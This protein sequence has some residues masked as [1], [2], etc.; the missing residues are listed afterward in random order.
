MRG[1]AGAGSTQARTPTCTS[2]P[3]LALHPGLDLYGF[4]VLSNSDRAP[5][6]I[7]VL[8]TCL[9]CWKLDLLGPEVLVW[10]W[11]WLEACSFLRTVP[12]LDASNLEQLD[13]GLQAGL[14][15]TRRVPVWV[16]GWLEA[17]GF[18]QT[19]P[20]LDASNL[21]QLDLGLQAGLVQTRR[22]PVW[23]WGWFEAFGFLQT[24]P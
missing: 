20:W 9:A 4:R 23:V 6:L 22:V 7:L 15:Q 19:V 18:L 24:V 21:E 5:V 3:P 16:W 14:V 10:V 12:W 1:C 2:P 17:F 8:C 13:L 11:G